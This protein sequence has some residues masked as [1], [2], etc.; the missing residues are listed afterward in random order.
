METLASTPDQFKAMARDESKRWGPIIKA[1][2][3]TLD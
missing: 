1:T 2:N 3:I